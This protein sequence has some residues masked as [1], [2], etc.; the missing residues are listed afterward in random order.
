MQ[1][2]RF[3]ISMLSLPFSFPY[4]VL[5]Q[6]RKKTSID[7]QNLDC[8]HFLVLERRK[9]S[10]NLVMDEFHWMLISFVYLSEILGGSM[11]LLKYWRLLVYNVVFMEVNMGVLGQNIL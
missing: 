9:G 3:T 8:S 10:N 11:S 4:Y 6:S 1:I 5:P 2:I 7:L